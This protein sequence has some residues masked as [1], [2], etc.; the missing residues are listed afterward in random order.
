MACTEKLALTLTDR[1][2][3]VVEVSVFGSLVVVSVAS[4]DS[5]LVV[6]VEVSA[7]SVAVS[8]AMGTLLKS[9][10]VP[11]SSPAIAPIC[12]VGS[13]VFDLAATSDDAMAVSTR[14]F[15]LES[16]ATTNPITSAIS[17][18]AAAA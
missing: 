4:A 12:L 16:V 2:G 7:M 5:L 10:E 1:L 11:A 8:L 15:R 14:S 13:P 6:S 9:P 18:T 17:A 3:A